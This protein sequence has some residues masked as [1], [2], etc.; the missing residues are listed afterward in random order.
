MPS[1]VQIYSK[2]AEETAVEIT[3]TPQ[4][5]TTFL[6]TMAQV[7]K[8]SYNDQLLIYAQRPDATACATY[9]IWLQRMGRYVKRGS[10]GIALLDVTGDY[11]KIKYVFDVS[12]TGTTEK[13]RTP[14]LWEY[15]PEHEAIVREALYQKHAVGGITLADQL[16]ETVKFEVDDYWYAHKNDI[17]HNID[18]SMLQDY[19]EDSIRMSFVEAASASAGY[20]LLTRCGM[21]TKQRY[22]D[23]DFIQVMDFNIPDAVFSLGSAVSICSESILREIE[24]VVKKYEREKHSER[25]SNYEQSDL[26][27]QRGLSDPQSGAVR[28]VPEASEQVRENAESLSAGEQTGTVVQPDPVR[29]AVSPSEGNRRDGESENGE[30]DGSAS[31]VGWRD[32]AD[33]AG[34]SHEMGGNDEYA[35]AAGRRSDSEGTDLRIE[36]SLEAQVSFFPSELEQIEYL[37]QAERVEITPSAFAFPQEVADQVLRIGGNSDHHRMAILAEFSKGKGLSSNAAFIKT[38]YHGGNGL[39]Y[40]GTSVCAWFTD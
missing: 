39:V 8:Y 6:R 5:W 1:R 9:D 30:H 32:G 35:E 13:S 3:G 40:N 19:N 15:K 24:I 25:S 23:V 20:V 11:P 17:L 31:E 4:Q 28:P 26:Q 27:N 2:L 14:N 36:A 7:Y 16:E 12:D 10:S 38:L 18:G 21:D 37:E 22:Q 34:E 29:E 33:E